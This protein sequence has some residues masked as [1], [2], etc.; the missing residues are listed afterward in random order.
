MLTNTKY[1]D[2]NIKILDLI[3]TYLTISRMLEYEIK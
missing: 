3:V 2:M 1:E